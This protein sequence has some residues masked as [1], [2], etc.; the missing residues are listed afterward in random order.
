MINLTNCHTE[1]ILH[2]HRVYFKIG[3][4]KRRESRLN[5]QF[6]L[7]DFPDSAERSGEEA[8]YLYRQ[9]LQEQIAESP[10]GPVATEINLLID[11]HL[12]GS[13]VEIMVFPNAAHGQALVR[14][15]LDMA[16]EKEPTETPSSLLYLMQKSHESEALVTS[17]DGTKY[18]I[19][20]LVKDEYKTH[21]YARGKQHH[22]YTVLP[23]YIRNDLSRA[24]KQFNLAYWENERLL[25]RPEDRFDTH[26][27]V[28]FSNRDDGF[29]EI[30]HILEEVDADQIAA[31]RAI[32]TWY[33]RRDLMRH[34][35]LTELVPVADGYIA[36]NTVIHGGERD[37]RIG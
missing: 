1:S 13:I 10:R 17:E 5:N 34:Q 9:W 29:V 28:H 18:L 23:K 7:V 22:V 2:R 21:F 11:A 20:P 8:A 4:T 24:L 12:R 19:V 37:K 6:W 26:E 31:E 16:E 33:Q 32:T 14:L 25:S 30:D 3:N 36:T 15:L 27:E 35:E